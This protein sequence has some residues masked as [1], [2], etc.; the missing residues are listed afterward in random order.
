MHWL[1]LQKVDVAVISETHWS[2][3]EEWSTQNW[4]VLHCGAESNF[5]T[6]RS[7]GIF[8]LISKRICSQSQLA[9]SSIIPGKLVHCR[10]YLQ[11]QT[12][13]IIGLYQHVWMNTKQQMETRQQFWT[14]LGNLFQK[15]PSR[16]LMIVLVDFNCSLPAVSRLVGTDTFHTRHGRLRGPQHSDKYDLVQVLQDYNLVALNTW[17]RDHGPTFKGHFDRNSRIDF[18]VT[19]LHSADAISKQVGH[20]VDAPFVPEGTHHVPMLAT[21]SYNSCKQC[22]RST[23]LFSHSLKNRCINDSRED[24]LTWQKCQNDIDENLRN[25]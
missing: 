19:R 20:L 14:R 9:W 2:M 11:K 25:A 8:V 4:H 3:N 12:I 18:I 10:M 22:R 7:S 24:T 23:M 17:T 16:N 21:L 1:F 5:S 13:D 15:I 6:D